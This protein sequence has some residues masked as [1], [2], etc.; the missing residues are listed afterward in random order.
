MDSDASSDCDLDIEE[1]EEPAAKNLSEE[2][3]RTLIEK[4]IYM[5]SHRLDSL[6]PADD[7][8]YLSY[9]KRHENNSSNSL[10]DSVDGI[11]ENL[12]QILTTDSLA[13]M[14]QSDSD[15]DEIFIVDSKLSQQQDKQQHQQQ[16]KQ[17]HQQQ[18]QQQH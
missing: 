17:Q 8:Y 10:T 9:D 13:L 18:D 4:H 3:I 11:I 14:Q 6:T 12:Q 1:L 16:D 2:Q 15:D 5:L 7:H